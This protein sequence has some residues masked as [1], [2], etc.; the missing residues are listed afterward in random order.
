[1]ISGVLK[2]TSCFPIHINT[3]WCGLLSSRMM[4]I[5]GPAASTDIFIFTTRLQKT[6]KRFILLNWAVILSV[7]WQKMPKE[8]YGSVCTTEKLPSGIKSKINFTRSMTASKQQQTTE[9]L[10][11]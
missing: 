5:Y 11:L 7:A 10:F 3:I 2:R 4:E 1:M 8:I 9:H 6:S